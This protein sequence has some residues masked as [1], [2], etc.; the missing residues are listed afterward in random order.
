MTRPVLGVLG[1]GQLGRMIGLAALPLG[2]RCRFIDPAGDAA[3]AA[4]VGPV[5]AGTLDDVALAER[6]MAGVDALTYE[7]EGVPAGTVHAL[8]DSGVTVSPGALALEI[9]Q[10]RL[11]EKQAAEVS[12]IPTASYAPVDTSGGLER[13]LE[14]IG[15][16]AILKTRRG[17]YDG[18]GQRLL[19]SRADVEGAWGELGGVPLI[20]ERVVEFS[21][22]L[23]V[24]AV[25]GRDG[26]IRTWPLVE[27]RHGNG[28]LR[29]SIAPAPGVS[30]SVAAA[31]QSIASRFLED[32]DYVGVLA[33]ELFDTDAGLVVNELA[34]RVHNSGHWTIEGAETSQFE[35]HVRAVL[36]LPLGSTEPRGSSA[37]VNCIGAEPDLDAVLS[38]PGTHWHGYDKEPRTGRKLGHVTVTAADPTERDRRLAAVLALRH[39][40][41]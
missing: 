8:A 7:W 28:I 13:A 41:G 14:T 11:S 25:R 9:S 5:T 15:F 33:I 32:F 26:S 18:K 10:D 22:E 37:M 36:G 16:P 38:I 35:N 3:P 20:L 19:R 2:I 40:V 12:Q 21:R 4:A 24:L 39:D 31:A 30:D 1:G 17:G 29:V 6:T 27:N 34:P 23:S